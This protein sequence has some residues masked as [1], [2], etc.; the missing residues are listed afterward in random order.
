MYLVITSSKD[1]YITNKVIDQKFRATDANVGKAATLDLFK[2]FDETS[3]TGS[4]SGNE[5]S[6]VLIKFDYDKLTSLTSKN[7]NI[8]DSSFFCKLKL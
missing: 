6:R 4:N 8:N 5:F 2:M 1:S 7:L 3:I